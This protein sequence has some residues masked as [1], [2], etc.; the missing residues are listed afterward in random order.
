KGAIHPALGAALSGPA[1]A[2]K[3]SC[4]PCGRIIPPSPT[5]PRSS[6]NMRILAIVLGLAF[7][8]ITIVYWLVPAGSLPS[9]FPG[10]EAGSPHVHVKHGLAAA[11]VAV[12]LFAVAWYAGRSRA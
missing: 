3:K 9:V 1:L 12:V 5:L 11:V 4:H 10:F 7:A 2:Y 6:S 8:V